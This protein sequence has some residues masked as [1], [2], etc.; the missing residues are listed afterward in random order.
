[1][2]DE[3]NPQC[4]LCEDE[5]PDRDR[6]YYADLDTEYEGKPLCESCYC[7]AEPAAT[8]YYD[9]DETPCFITPVRNDTEGQFWVTWH[10]TDPW[11][12]YY[13]LHASDYSCVLTD[14]LRAWH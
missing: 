14:A 12:G 9:D 13:E 3:D 2:T 7:E 4:V 11:R 5:L 6:I 1:M 10:S 8:L